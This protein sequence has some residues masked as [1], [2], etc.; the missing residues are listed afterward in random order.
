MKYTLAI[1]LMLFGYGAKAQDTTT[2]RIAPPIAPVINLRIDTTE[3]VYTPKGKVL[4]YHQYKAL[5]ASGKFRI[6]VEGDVN[7][8]DRKLYLKRL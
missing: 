2:F 8:K 4:Q 3:V 7:S 1:A 6:R 5:I